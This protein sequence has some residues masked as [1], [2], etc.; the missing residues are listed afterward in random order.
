[1]GRLVLHGGYHLHPSR[2]LPL[3]LIQALD[4]EQNLVG[5]IVCKLEPHRGGPLRGYI[6]MLATR[7]QYRGQGI[8]SKLVRMA[9]QKMIEKDADEVVS[10]LSCIITGAEK[11]R[12]LSKPKLTTFL[13]S[14]YTRT[15]AFSGPSDYIVIT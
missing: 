9:V 4:G 14:V 12:L 5:V 6:A 11:Y 7:A 8:A 10:P 1:M 3:T 2:K 13:P 15:W